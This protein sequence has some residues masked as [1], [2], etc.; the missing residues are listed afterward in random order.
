MYFWR[1]DTRE[2][3][4]VKWEKCDGVRGAADDVSRTSR[5]EFRPDMR[6]RLEETP[7]G[8]HEVDVGGVV[9]DSWWSA[10]SVEAVAVSVEEGI[11]GFG[12]GISG[13]AA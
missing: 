1:K 9:V 13:A 10:V 7:W 11:R 3:Q 4:C 6:R 2:S 12:G 5:G 8:R